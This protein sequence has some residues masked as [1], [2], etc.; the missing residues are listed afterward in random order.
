MREK[1]GLAVIRTPHVG[2]R[3][4]TEPELGRVVKRKNHAVLLASFASRLEVRLEDS[5]R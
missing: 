3:L 4:S 1:A 5:F 2:S